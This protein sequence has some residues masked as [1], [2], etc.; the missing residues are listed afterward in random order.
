[1]SEITTKQRRAAVRRIKEM[2]FSNLRRLYDTQKLSKDDYRATHTLVLDLE[3]LLE[4]MDDRG[5][6][7]EQ[8]L[9]FI[10]EDDKRY[11]EEIF[12]QP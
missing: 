10:S 5:L 9:Q 12:S 3:K 7:W 11:H 2:T 1:M 8:L 6:T 4:S